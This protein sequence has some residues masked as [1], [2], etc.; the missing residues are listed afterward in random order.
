VRQWSTRCARRISGDQSRTRCARRFATRGESLTRGLAN[1]MGDVHKRRISQT[2]ETAFEVGRNLA[3]TPGEVVFENELIQLIQYQATTPQVAKRPLVM[4]PPCINKFY[5]LDLQPENSFVAHAVASGHTAFMVSWRNVESEQGRF[6]WDDYLED[7]VFARC[8]WRRKSPRATR[9]TRS[10]FAS[11][12]RC[13]GAG[14][15][16]SRRNPGLVA[17]ATFP[18]R[19]ARLR[20]AG[21]IGLFIDADRALLRAKQ[22]SART[23][24][25][26][27]RT[28]RSCSP[29]CAPTIWCGPYVVSNYLRGEQPPAFDLLYWNSDSTNL[30]GPMYCYYLR[31]TYLE[32]RLRE[33]GASPIAACRSTSRR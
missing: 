18:R 5:I 8:A 25:C 12:A 15:R 26:R 6:G 27:A 10:V 22:P 1:L 31:N 30:P 9:S 3:V 13:S 17:S 11:A 20:G 28:S 24:S 16:C 29:A 4:I 7:G 14:W 32:N 23:A 33:P 19:D 21:Q 2:N